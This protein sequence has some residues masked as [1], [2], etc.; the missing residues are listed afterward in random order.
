M[1]LDTRT[2]LIETAI[3][4]ARLRGYTAFSYADIAE[5]VGIRK[6]SIHHHFPS[7]EDLGVAIVEAY[8]AE[9]ARRLSGITVEMTD[10]LLRLEAYAGLYREALKAGRGCLCGVL[11]SEIAALPPRV[12]LAVRQFLALHLDWL[13]RTLA[14]DGGFGRLRHDIVPARD[15]GTVLA[16]LQ[17]ALSMSLALRQPRN[18]EHAVGGLL[19][20][21][22]HHSQ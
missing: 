4:F 7:K 9:F 20:G 1:S 18:F 11:A 2:I 19:A 12:Q 3:D 10:P 14:E 6:P 21:L 16:T 15:A 5:A 8:M 22:A 17:G 13:E